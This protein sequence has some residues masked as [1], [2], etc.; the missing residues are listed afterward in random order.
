LFFFNLG[1]NGQGPGFQLKRNT[2]NRFFELK[3]ADLKYSW[4]IFLNDFPTYWF[5]FA[6]TW[7]KNTGLKLF[8]N[9][10]EKL[11]SKTRTLVNKI[12]N[13]AKH[14]ISSST[15]PSKSYERNDYAEIS[16]AKNNPKLR[17]GKFGA[18]DLGHV[19]FWNRALAGDDVSNVYKADVMI[20]ITDQDCCMKKRGKG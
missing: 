16:F 6:F 13:N 5:H 1:T 10:E 19:A 17:D 14:Q 8:I 12:S 15:S 4:S 2:K 7:D 3:V 20:D 18:F 9:G 11:S